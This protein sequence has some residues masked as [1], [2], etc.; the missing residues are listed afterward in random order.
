[1]Q[2]HE[3]VNE[4]D[5]VRGC[6]S[7]MGIYYPS[8]WNQ[9][10]KPA[11]P[12][13]LILTHTHVGKGHLKRNAPLSVQS[14]RLPPEPPPASAAPPSAGPPQSLGDAPVAPGSQ[15][16]NHPNKPYLVVWRGDLKAVLWDG[17]PPLQTN[18]GHK[19]DK[20]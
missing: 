2:P 1:M 7:K 18:P 3:W 10:L 16:A 13:A 19:L 6:G 8:K 20:S 12:G 15:E 11:V 4:C 17:K 5:V 9:G 14:L